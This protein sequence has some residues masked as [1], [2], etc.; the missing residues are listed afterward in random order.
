MPIKDHAAELASGW[1]GGAAGVLCSHPLD[2]ARVRIQLARPNESVGLLPVL[3]DCVRREGFAG[4]FRGIASPLVCVG[5]WKA[6]TF[7]GNAAALN[8]FRPGGSSAASVPELASAAAFGAVCG[9]VVATPMEMVKC[10]AQADK[11]NPAGLVA[12]WRMLRRIVSS[13]GMAS[14]FVGCTMN[15]VASLFSMPVWFVTNELMLRQRA[16]FWQ[17]R[18]HIPS[19]EKICC[20]ALGGVLSWIPAYPFDKLKTL[21]QTHHQSGVLHANDSLLRFMRDKLRKEGASFVFRGLSATVVRAV[22]QTGMTIFVYNL[23]RGR[24]D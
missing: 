18:E 14:L 11:H 9:A 5:I 17:G 2:T 3:R 16:S 22:P 1:L 10:N 12:E 24:L 23:V 13:G 8:T 4:L 21:W 20:G 19:H 15:C 7:A 6:T